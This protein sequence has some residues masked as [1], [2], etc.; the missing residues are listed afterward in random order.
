MMD[1]S[2][3]NSSEAINYNDEESSR[4]AQFSA[5]AFASLLF[6]FIPVEGLEALTL[7]EVPLKLWGLRSRLVW[8]QLFSAARLWLT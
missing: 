6:H 3:E 8:K 7:F 5:V 2:I 1:L 4:R